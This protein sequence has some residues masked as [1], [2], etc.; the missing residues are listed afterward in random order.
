MGL[1]V[2]SDLPSQ[3]PAYMGKGGEVLDGGNAGPQNDVLRKKFRVIRC[4]VDLQ[5]EPHRVCE[6]WR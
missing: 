1:N 2:A 6:W 4:I 3:A 5:A